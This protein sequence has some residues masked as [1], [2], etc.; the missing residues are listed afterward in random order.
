MSP[1]DR[2][3]VT[4]MAWTTALGDDPEGVWSRLCAGETG[5]L[6]VAAQRAGRLRNDRAGMVSAFPPDQ[7][8][9]ERLAAMTRETLAR[10]LAVAGRAPTDP[11]LR[12]ILGTSFGSY[13][14][15]DPP[16]P[17]AYAWA[18]RVAQAMG[19]REPPWLISTACSAGSDAIQVG[20]ALI[21]E[22]MADACVCGGVDILTWCKRLS[23][24]A[25]GTLSP[26]LLRAF[27]MRHDG[28]LFGEGAAFLVLEAPSKRTPPLAWLRGCGSSSDATGMTAPDTTGVAVGLAIERSLADAGLTAGQ[29]GV[30][31]AHASGTPMNDRAEKEALGRLFAHPPQPL[32]FGTKGNFGH[33]LGATGAMEAMALIL[34]LRHRQVSPVYGLE[35]PEPDFPLPL[36]MGRPAEL[37]NPIGLSLTL[38]FGG[39]DTSLIFEVP[40]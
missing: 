11:G 21:R 40:L 37:R 36:V 3:H 25:L 22:G 7:P 14:E 34:A 38:G 31:N 33:T 8:P 12:L 10:A 17:S 23:H 5:L 19:F 4:G 6:P 20:A 24:S 13:L 15:D 39:F 29:I 28:T 1:M 9:P 2:C 30:I 27:D 32:L 16:E 26:T 18:D 35:Q